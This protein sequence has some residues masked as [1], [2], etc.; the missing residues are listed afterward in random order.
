M[1]EADLAQL[2]FLLNDAKAVKQAITRHNN[3]RVQ[4]LLL[5]IF[6]FGYL[7]L[8][9]FTDVNPAS[10]VFV[11]FIWTAALLAWLFCA[12]QSMEIKKLKT[13]IRE[14]IAKIAGITIERFSES[15]IPSEALP[16]TSDS[17]TIR[18]RYLD[19]V[20]HLLL[21]LILPAIVT[22]IS[23]QVN[24]LNL[25]IYLSII[26]LAAVLYLLKK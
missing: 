18:S 15:L 24:L 4:A 3:Y 2:E 25:F 16:E 1:N 21:F 7:T 12:G 13:I 23:L 6:V 22:I 14:N 17:T 9:L 10:E 20:F 8:R 5:Y 19:D 26:I 11:A